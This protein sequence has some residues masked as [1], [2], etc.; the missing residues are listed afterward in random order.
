MVQHNS[1][2]SIAHINASPTKT[3]FVEMLTRDIELEDAIL[4]LLDNCV[5]GIQ[6]ITKDE[7]SS[8]NP[9]NNFWAKITFS[10]ENFR[11]EDNCGGIPKE[12]AEEYAFK[13]GRPTNVKNNIDRDVYTIGTYGIGMKRSIF[14]IGR[15]AEVISQTANESFK[16]TIHP[17]WLTRDNDW[18]LPFETISCSSEI[19]GTSITVTSLYEGISEEF[20][21]S[22]STLLDRLITKISRYY[23]FILHK[24]FTVTVNGKNVIPKSWSL[25]WGGSEQL[26]KE[27][28]IAPYLYKAQSNDVD[29]RLAI[30][31]YRSMPGENEIEGEINGTKRRSEEA[32]WT[33]VCNDRVV[34]YCDKTFLTGWGET[35]IPRFHAQFI[36]ISGIVE[37][38]SKDSKKLPITTTKRGIDASSDIYLYVKNFMREGLKYLTSYINK[39]RIDIVEEKK[40]SEQAYPINPD[41][42][43]EGDIIPREKWTPVRN[44]SYESKYIP[45]LPLP[46]NTR[47]KKALNKNIKFSKSLQEIKLLA[48]FLFEDSE[49]DPSEV[50]EECFERTLKEAQ[51]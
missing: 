33:I 7:Q 36:G 5:D 38:R 13:M 18:D 4:D 25:L 22:K 39:W 24:G 6:R 42:L 35:T 10:N 3:F 50:G 29:V 21:S 30:G 32:G 45:A 12:V 51:K 34:V 26:A 48:E 11:I 14:K 44:R 2:N 15:S 17:E 8:T 20:L 46:M 28:I 41:D 16:V 43:F 49:R 23:S 9:Y 19:N 31:F 37:F 1:A 47:G 27:S 40:R